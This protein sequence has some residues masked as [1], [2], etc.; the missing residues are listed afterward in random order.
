MKVD[1]KNTHTI[2]ML[3]SFVC[4]ALVVGG[5]WFWSLNSS[6]ITFDSA[7]TSGNIFQVASS[8]GDNYFT[9]TADGR[10]GVRNQAP[11]T[12]LDV[13]GMIRTY[14]TEPRECTTAIEGAIRYDALYKKFLGCNGV[15]WRRLDGAP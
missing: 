15:E 1:M 7:D 12:E 10:V 6:G 14:S 11:T 2:L 4:G 3:A 9:V 5:M 13:Y 8:T